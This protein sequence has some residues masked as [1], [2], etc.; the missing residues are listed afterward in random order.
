[1]ELLRTSFIAAS[2]E[3]HEQWEKMFVRGM[4]LDG[5]RRL[6]PIFKQ[7]FDAPFG[8]SL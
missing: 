6:S 3:S 4:V 5:E 8:Q 1:M 2:P 7:V